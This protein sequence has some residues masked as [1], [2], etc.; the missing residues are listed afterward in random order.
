MSCVAHM[1][2]KCSWHTR[3]PIVLFARRI[4]ISTP[5]CNYAATWQHWC[6]HHGGS[7]GW[8]PCVEHLV[9]VPVYRSAHRHALFFGIR[10]DTMQNYIT[11]LISLLPVYWHI[12]WPMVMMRQLSG[13]LHTC[14]V[15]RWSRMD[16][17]LCVH[18]DG[19]NHLMNG[20]QPKLNK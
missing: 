1:E 15:P 7:R 18:H 16:E 3:C 2:S 6:L 20:S 8:A 10:W 12:L 19:N 14:S 11:M 9:F 13:R 17:R 4:F 5:M